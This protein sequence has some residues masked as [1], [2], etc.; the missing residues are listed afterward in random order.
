M[1][2][3]LKYFSNNLAS[4]INLLEVRFLFAFIVWSSRH[5]SYCYSSK[6]MD[7]HNVRNIVFSSSATVYGDVSV[8]FFFLTDFLLFF[9]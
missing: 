1:K 3:P 6:V 5:S 7:K 8:F 2:L 4:T 9:L